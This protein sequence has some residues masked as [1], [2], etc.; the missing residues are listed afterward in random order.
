MSAGRSRKGGALVGGG[1]GLA[2]GLLLG[3]AISGDCVRDC[4]DFYG[5]GGDGLAEANATGLGALLG[6][7]ILGGVGAGVGAYFAP[8]QW[9]SIA[10]DSAG[11]ITPMLRLRR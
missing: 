5:I 2:A 4:D 9:V 3:T 10:L 6:G 11:R 7:V 8:E 1:I